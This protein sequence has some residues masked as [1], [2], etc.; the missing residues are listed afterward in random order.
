EALIG[1][2]NL[3]ALNEM[4]SKKPK[5]TK[6]TLTN[7]QRKD[8]IN[9]K[10]KNP[11]ISQADLVSWVKQTMG[12]TVHQ[13]TIS[14]LIK[15]KEEIRENPMG[16]DREQF[17]THLEP[18]TTLA[19]VRLKGKKINK[20][21]LTLA[22][23]TNADGTDKMMPF[24]IAWMTVLLFQKWLKKFDLK[25]AGHKVILLMGNAKVHSVGNLKLHNTTIKFFPP[26]TTSRLQPMD[27]EI[28][29]LVQDN[30][31]EPTTDNDDDIIEEL[32]R[33][34]ELLNFQ[35]IM[36]L[37]EYID[38]SEEKI[39][40]GIISDQEILNQAMYQKPQQVE[41]D[42]ED[43]SVEMPQI[44]YKEALDAVHWM[45]LYL[46]QQDLNYMVQT[47]Y[48]IALSKLYKLVRMLQNASFKQLSIETFFEPV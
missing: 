32:Y 20:E 8:I 21:Q 14:R 44:T 26:Y 39:V 25:M 10:E 41:S 37:E 22:L 18:N 23:C 31:E 5:E 33:N 36:D 4:S 11:Q 1:L 3:F 42:E 2:I 29:P 47:E 48:D 24:V 28:L 35:N 27:A 9:Y 45:E 40:T 34:I 46:M 12:L 6:T 15:N 43:N 19:T 38:Y 16:K 17:N 7:E 13:T 30:N